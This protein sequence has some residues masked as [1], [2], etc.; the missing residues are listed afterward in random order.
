MPKKPIDWSSQNLSYKSL[1]NEDLSHADL[2]GTI[3]YGTDL[4]YASLYGADMTGART[5]ASTNWYGADMRNVTG[6]PYIPMVCPSH[7]PFVGWKVALK[8]QG[9]RMERCIVKLW[10]PSDAKR[11]SGTIRYCRCDKA[12]VEAIEGAT[13]AWSMNDPGMKYEIGA[14]VYADKFDEDR[15]ESYGHGIYFFIDREEAVRYME[16]WR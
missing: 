4:S 14:F 6:M 10:I 11:V 12:R 13:E 3:L 8:E 5:N 7:G 16:E 9:H 15:W 2:R 1:R